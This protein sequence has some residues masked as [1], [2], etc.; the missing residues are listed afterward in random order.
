MVRDAG[1]ITRGQ[2]TARIADIYGWAFSSGPL[3]DSASHATIP[4]VKG[5]Q[6]LMQRVGARGHAT[7]GGRLAPDAKG[8]PASML[9]KK[10]AGAWRD[11][12]EVRAWATAIAAELR[13]DPGTPA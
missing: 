10:R 12:A 13:H 1:G 4:P 8:Y 5:V 11:P 2:L 9:A 7:F 3:D 6:A